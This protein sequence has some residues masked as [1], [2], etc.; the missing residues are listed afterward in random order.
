MIVALHPQHLPEIAALREPILVAI[1]NAPAP[2]PIW[3]KVVPPLVQTAV[4][5]IG[6]LWAAHHGAIVGARKT[7]EATVEAQRRLQRE[8]DARSLNLMKDRL[9]WHVRQLVAMVDVMETVHG[10]AIPVNKALLASLDLIWDGFYRRGESL[11]L[12]EDPDYRA[13]V[14][15][16]YDSVRIRATELR[17]FEEGVEANR[18]H[19]QAGI[20]LSETRGRILTVLR[21]VAGEGAGLVEEL[22]PR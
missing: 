20:E 16:F 9:R 12:L 13:R 22:G 2:E 4:A 8:L 5:V 19:P 15:S 11:L 10:T 14:E 7:L 1:A 17:E 21:R 18:L 6:A 3:A